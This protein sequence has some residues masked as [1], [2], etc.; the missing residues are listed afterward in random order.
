MLVFFEVGPKE[1]KKKKLG[2]SFQEFSSRHLEMS[3]KCS[4]ITQSS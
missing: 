1:K 4:S 3:E 2:D